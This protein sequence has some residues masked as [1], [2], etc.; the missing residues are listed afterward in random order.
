MKQD[1]EKIYNCALMALAIITIF[2]VIFSFYDSS[3]FVGVTDHSFDAERDKN[4]KDKIFN[5]LYYTMSSLSTSDG[6]LLPKTREVQII[7]MLLQFIVILGAL[8][9]FI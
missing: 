2:T 4:L 1:M 3:H 5:R 6:V 7:S 8:T 9:L